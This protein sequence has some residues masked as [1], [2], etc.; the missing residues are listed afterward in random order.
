MSKAKVLVYKAMTI[1]VVVMG[2]GGAVDKVQEK[3]K[4]GKIMEVYEKVMVFKKIKI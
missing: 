4:K 1:K 3:G 2:V